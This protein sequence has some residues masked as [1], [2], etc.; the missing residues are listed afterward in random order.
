M[1]MASNHCREI[2]YQCKCK[3]RDAAH[4]FSRTY[5]LGRDVHS[6][7]A[8]SMSNIMLERKLQLRVVF[9]ILHFGGI[10]FCGD[11]LTICFF[12]LLVIYEKR[13]MMCHLST[14][15]R[16]LHFVFFEYQD[17]W[18]MHVVGTYRILLV[19]LQPDKL[20]PAER[21]SVFFPSSWY[22]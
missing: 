12:G 20:K 8:F 6:Q 2:L 14:R 17:G 9:C 18:K 7:V 11:R 1:R 21:R 16:S 15:K 5:M 13:C 10:L 3:E 19:T 4:Q 22:L